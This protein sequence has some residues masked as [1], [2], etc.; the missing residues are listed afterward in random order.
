MPYETTVIAGSFTSG[1]KDVKITRTMHPEL[2]ILEV[3]ASP[4]P[5]GIAHGLTAYLSKFPYL[6]TEQLVSRTFPAIVLQAGT[7][8]SELDGR[9]VFRFALKIAGAIIRQVAA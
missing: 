2:R 6:C 9:V 7:D 1:T 4:L 5:I 3:S 8:P